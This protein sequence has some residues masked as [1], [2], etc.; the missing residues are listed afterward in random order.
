M[1]HGTALYVVFKVFALPHLPAEV[2]ALPHLP[3]E[4]CVWESN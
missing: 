3:A 4:V 2:F 1:K